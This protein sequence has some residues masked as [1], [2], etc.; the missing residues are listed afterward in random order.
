MTVQFALTNG[1]IAFMRQAET[2]NIPV[3]CLLFFAI[4]F[5]LC[6]PLYVIS[7]ND[8]LETSGPVASINPS[9]SQPI[10][11]IYMHM[12]ANYQLS[13]DASLAGSQLQITQVEHSPTCYPTYLWGN[14]CCFNT[15]IFGLFSLTE[16]KANWCILQSV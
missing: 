2:W 14:K 1:A 16:G 10:I 12:A 5:K 3:C 7:Q 15:Q 6:N 4:V 13:T 9:E 8:F 11:I